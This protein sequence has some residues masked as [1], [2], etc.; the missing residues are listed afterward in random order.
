[1]AADEI[2]SE[3]VDG[4]S[5]D[6]ASRLVSYFQSHARKVYCIL[7]ADP[8]V[9]GG[10]RVLLWIERAGLK[11]F[12]RRDAHYALCGTFQTAEELDRPLNT[13]ERHGFIRRRADPQ[14]PGPGRKPSPVFEVNP[15]H[16]SSTES[17]ESTK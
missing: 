8:K 7:D 13:L 4:E 2:E 1:M 9:A 6:R 12:S 14:H 17:T 10:R 3:D 15:L 5:L 11:E 16:T